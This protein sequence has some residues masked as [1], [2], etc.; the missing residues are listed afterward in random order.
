MSEK[1]FFIGSDFRA[2]FPSARIGVVVACDIDNGGVSE[3]KARLER[4]GAKALEGLGQTPLADHPDLACWRR[5]YKVFGAPK[6]H[7][8]SVEALVRRVASG[9]GIPTINPLVDLYNALSLEF[10]FPAGGEDLD[11]V[12]GD[13]RL[14]LAAGGESFVPLG[15]DESDPPRQGEVI[16]RDDEGVLCRCWNWR[17]ARRTCLSPSTKRALLVMENLDPGRDDAFGAALLALA[18]GVERLGGRGE[19]HLLDGEENAFLLPSR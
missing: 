8:S 12:V 15:A 1:R 5:A 16:Y 9:K 4:A 2:L 17:E 13:V 10:L 14:V 11:A 3:G 6:G 7:R 18:E 19:I